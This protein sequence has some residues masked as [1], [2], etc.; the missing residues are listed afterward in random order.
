LSLS[1]VAGCTRQPDPK[2]EP[3]AAAPEPT[4]GTVK[5]P[6]KKATAPATPEAAKPAPEK[7]LLVTAADLVKAFNADRAAAAQR[8]RGKTL[9]VEGVVSVIEQPDE[10][11]GGALTL[12]GLP[13][14]EIEPGKVKEVF[15]NLRYGQRDT[16]RVREDQPVQIKGVCTG[17]GFQQ[18]VELANATVEIVRRIPEDVMKK[19]DEAEKALALLKGLGVGYT[20]SAGGFWEIYLRPE[21]VAANGRLRPDVLAALLKIPRLRGISV[22][23][24]SLNDAGLEGLKEFTRLEK[25]SLEGTQVTDAGLVHLKALTRLRSLELAG[26]VVTTAALDQL[27]GLKYLDTLGLAGTQVNDAGL[28]QLKLFP[29][30]RALY[31]T[32]TAVSDAGLG[33]L[34]GLPALAEL[35]LAKTKITDAGLKYLGGL[36]QLK[37]LTV[38]K[39]GVTMAAVNQLKEAMPALEVKFID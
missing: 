1:F 39:K 31:L 8:Y 5:A 36:K 20:D 15:C 16:G 22:E 9:Y 19:K 30:L 37:L 26:T 13:P 21:H 17:V 27:Q 24:T 32:D 14:E 25:L 6:G 7:P 33:H 2:P 28:A 10:G 34:A 18:A 35:N 4:P 23:L 38:S 3:E 11:I 12:E 29:R